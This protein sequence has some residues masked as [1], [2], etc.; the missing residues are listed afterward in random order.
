MSKGSSITRAT[1]S[2][3][4]EYH[5]NNAM[6]PLNWFAA[7]AEAALMSGVILSGDMFVKISCLCLVVLVLLFYAYVYYYFMRKD[8]DRL[9]SEGYNLRTQELTLISQDIETLP[10]VKVINEP[11]ASASSSGNLVDASI[12]RPALKPAASREQDMHPEEG[13]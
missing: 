6:T 12:E 8:P 4:G 7:I 13:K 10:E 5:K 2:K 11:S 9:Q 3:G 1:R